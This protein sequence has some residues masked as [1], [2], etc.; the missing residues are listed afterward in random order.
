[1]G[2]RIHCPN[3][4][5]LN[6][7]AF[8]AG[9]RG[10]CPHCGAK[11]D[12]PADQ[13]TTPGDTTGDE[14]STVSRNVSAAAEPLSISGLVAPSGPLE[15]T[16][17]TPAV[18]I[19]QLDSETAF[20]DSSEPSSAPNTAGS[21][22]APLTAPSAVVAATSQTGVDPLEQAP[23]AA[24]Y[25]R[26]PVHGQFGPATGDLLR[27]WAAEGRLAADWLVWRKGWDDWQPAPSILPDLDAPP[28]EIGAGL[29][30][31]GTSDLDTLAASAGT[32]LAS[33]YHGPAR[34]RTNQTMRIV[35][36]A[37]AFA[38][39][40]LLAVLVYVLTRQRQY[41]RAGSSSQ[42]LV[43]LQ[44]ARPNVH[45]EFLTPGSGLLTPHF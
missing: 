18:A 40:I 33:V 21:G 38:V 32:R 19:G 22:A 25:V 11:F 23:G 14:I 36:A 13:N 29:F 15:T 1:M 39:L 31:Q 34:R 43:A 9:K 45:V 5:R 30:S 7:K 12:I 8:L 27:Q 41:G 10:V 28:A 6:V 24:W 17:A 4:H 37:L 44:F 42:S 3:G 2:I 26:H 20:G 35:S 16:V